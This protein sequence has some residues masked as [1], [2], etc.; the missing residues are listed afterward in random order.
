MTIEYVC[1]G[2]KS[3]ISRAVHLGRL[4][5]FYPACRRCSHRDDTGTLSARRV[6]QL[7][8]T[9]RRGQRP[10][11]FFE[12]G[13]AGVLGSDLDATVARRLGAA[14]GIYLRHQPSG[15]EPPMAVI[16]GDGRPSAAELLAAAGEGL[17]DEFA[18]QGVEIGRAAWRERG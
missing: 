14:L 16:A 5:G 11:L 1:P 8:D 18:G 3:P 7:V 2:E 9:R 10:P 12:E 15:A 17:V 4:A 6:K 13:A